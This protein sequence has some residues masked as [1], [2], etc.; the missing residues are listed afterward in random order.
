M[1]NYIGYA[2]S[3]GEENIYKTIDF[4]KENNM[5]AVEI[6]MNVPIYFPENFNKEE[7]RKIKDYAETNGVKLTM[8]APEDITLLQLHSSIRKAGLD[9]L[10]EIITF[11]IDIG[12][13]RMTL[14]VGSAVCFT[15]VDRKSYME[16]FYEKE[17]KNILKESLQQLVHH[18][19][20]KLMICVENS[21]RFPKK[22]VQE[23]L[24]ELL[25]TTNL[26]LTWDIGHS[27]ENKYNEV[28]FFIRNIDKIR[29]CHIH[30][31]NGKSD[32]QIIGTGNLDFNK[33]FNLM[34]DKEIIYIIEVRP[35][36]NAVKSLEILKKH[37]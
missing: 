7:R 18:T 30:D 6:N 21:G 32:H 25:K 1:F 11:G 9:R 24:E 3:I 28:E 15:L 8:H 19:E 34:K 2:A 22:I 17:Y 23:V 12:V 35:R 4:A 20:D 36:E 29:T 27:Y 31:N 5:N 13:S 33:H 16:E 26:Y 14:H 10:K 37:F